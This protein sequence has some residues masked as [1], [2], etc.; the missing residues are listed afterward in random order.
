MTMQSFVGKNCKRKLSLLIVLISI[1]S[2]NFFGAAVWGQQPAPS[3]PSTSAADNPD[4]K[5]AA[6]STSAFAPT[7]VIHGF[8]SQAYAFSDGNQIIGIP[9]QGT[10]DYRAA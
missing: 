4:K 6:K 8:L 1:G 10:A 5:V 7:L 3:E 9:K 2:M